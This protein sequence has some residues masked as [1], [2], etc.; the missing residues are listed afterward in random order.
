VNLP[1]DVGNQRASAACILSASSIVQALMVSFS[2]L[3][4]QRDCGH[5]ARE[6]GD[7]LGLAQE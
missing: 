6:A 7:A 4:L 3:S 1:S 2:L 5:R